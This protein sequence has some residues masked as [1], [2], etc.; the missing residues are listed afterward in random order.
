M[1]DNP[2][3]TRNLWL[4]AT[5][6]RLLLIPAVLGVVLLAAGLAV[7]VDELPRALFVI[8]CAGF[9]GGTLLW[10]VRLVGDAMHEECA[11]GTWDA[12]RMSGLPAWSLVLGKLFGG[13]SMGWYTG[14]WCLL[15]MLA[16]IGLGMPAGQVLSTVLRLAC[17]A[18]LVQAGALLAALLR[19][20]KARAT[21]VP[22][23]RASAASLV[24]I[25][26]ALWLL[27]YSFSG[28]PGLDVLEEDPRPVMWFG[29]AVPQVLFG[30]L[31]L[32]AYAGWALLAAVQLM[33]RE[34][35]EPVSDRWWSLF[36]LFTQLHLAGLVGGA[37]RG[38]ADG[39]A[40]AG[41]FA[42]AT[43][44][45]LL[46]CI[47]VAALVP[48]L[49]AYALVF[50]EPKPRV[51]LERLVAHL[52]AGRLRALAGE[53][54]LWLRT[55]LH[56]AA[57]LL[58]AMIVAVMDPVADMAFAALALA[59]LLFLLRDVAIVL[60]CNAG[61]SQRRSDAAALAYLV[62]L[63]AVLPL[64]AVVLE[65]PVML[66]AFQPHA[67]LEWPVVTTAAGVAWLLCAVLLL[68]LRWRGRGEGDA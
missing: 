26:L 68:R 59:L 13:G 66:A 3:F 12:Q 6:Q 21:H 24:A 44:S 16:S 11:A 53:A 58:L 38:A 2:E 65:A 22:A 7:D 62:L 15:P 48:F 5:P 49:L 32:A 50:A 42:L 20:R 67:A 25:G 51:Q 36:L 17:I 31:S 43:G 54:P 61:A 64:V 46:A 30:L 52:R 56:A 29:V 28:F 18:L 63:Y 4:E 41:M 45:S 34:L 40:G 57:T 27:M 1:I 9:V 60:T 23:P 10:G 39:T 55:L 14:A 33:R 8:G 37:A 35:L 47:A 19:L